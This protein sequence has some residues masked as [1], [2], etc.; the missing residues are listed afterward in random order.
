M[1]FPLCLWC[2][3]I[4]FNC[5]L[6]S[7]CHSLSTLFGNCWLGKIIIQNNSYWHAFPYIV[8]KTQ[9]KP[10]WNTIELA[11]NFDIKIICTGKALC[12]KKVYSWIMYLV[13]SKGKFCHICWLFYYITN[14]RT[15]GS[16]ID[17][18]K[19]ATIVQDTLLTTA[20]KLLIILMS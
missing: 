18:C 15:E 12:F 11:R 3:L 8:Q 13:H 9:N 2:F 19:K 20:K 5:D 1:H 14:K 10:H 17:T 6:F 16:C 7:I 4:C